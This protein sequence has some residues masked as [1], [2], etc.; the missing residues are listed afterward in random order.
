MSKTAKASENFGSPRANKTTHVVHVTT[1]S[2]PTVT[3]SGQVFWST[4]DLLFPSGHTVR[5][6]AKK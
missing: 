1:N 4:R 5:S 6:A 2:R 3:N